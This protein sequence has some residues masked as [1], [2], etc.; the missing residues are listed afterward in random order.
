MPDSYDPELALAAQ[1]HLK[2]ALVS[3]LALAP[4]VRDLIARANEHE[5][6]AI[7]LAYDKTSK[8]YALLTLPQ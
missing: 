1:A 2:F 8:L 3:F 4:A 7:E 5:D 6:F